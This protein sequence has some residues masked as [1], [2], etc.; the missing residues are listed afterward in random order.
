MES[1]MSTAAQV[2]IAVVPIVG[3]VIGGVVVFFYLL[4][5]NKQIT[6]LIAQGTYKAKNFDLRLFSLLTG[7]LLFGIGIVLSV[8]FFLLEGLTYTL[9]GGLIPLVLGLSLILFYKVYPKENNT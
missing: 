6:L 3:I 1:Q 9:L 7:L 2:V 4:W 5:R 8:F